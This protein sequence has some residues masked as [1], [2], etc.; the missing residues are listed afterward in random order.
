[1]QEGSPWSPMIPSV[2]IA[3]PENHVIAP[4]LS[5]EYQRTFHKQMKS[6]ETP[7]LNYDA[8]QF[9]AQLGVSILDRVELMGDLG[10]VSFDPFLLRGNEDGWV[11][12]VGLKAL[13]IRTKQ[14]AFSASGQ[15]QQTHL[16]SS[17]GVPSWFRWQVGFT[18]GWRISFFEPYAGFAYQKENIELNG[19]QFQENTPYT[20]IFGMRL[21]DEKYFSLGAEM[22]LFAETTLAFYASLRF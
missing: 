13:L 12:G 11:W 2:G 4:I 16:D 20:L 22:H 3:F 14:F 6:D 19:I 17:T 21:A 7:K 8:N 15:F 1:M 9:L 10:W 18:G 5:G